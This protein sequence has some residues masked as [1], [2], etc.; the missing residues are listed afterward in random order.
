MHPRKSGGEKSRYVALFGA[1]LKDGTDGLF[2][3][4]SAGD[5]AGLGH[6]AEEWS[7]GFGGCGRD[8]HLARIE[9]GVSQ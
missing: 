3:H 2:G 1:R 9:Q 8:D 4:R 6:R 5:F 7:W